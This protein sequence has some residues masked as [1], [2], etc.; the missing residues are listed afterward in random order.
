MS[1]N[2]IYALK[3]WFGVKVITTSHHANNAC[4]ILHPWTDINV[5]NQFHCNLTIFA[6]DVCNAGVFLGSDW[7]WNSD[8][9]FGVHLIVCDRMRVLAYYL[10]F[11]V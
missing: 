6:F 9:T 2:T 3:L 5:H 4:V 11:I 8:F 7:Q 1:G 10:L